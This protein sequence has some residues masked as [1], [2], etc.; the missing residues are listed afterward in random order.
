MKGGGEKNRK[1][2][3]QVLCSACIQLKVQK[4]G[5]HVKIKTRLI[6]MQP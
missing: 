6:Q 3:R 4:E 1:T 5:L 2:E